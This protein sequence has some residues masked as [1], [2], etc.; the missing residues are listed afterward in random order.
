MLSKKIFLK[1]SFSLQTPFQKIRF[2]KI[3]CRIGPK[4]G[5]MFLVVII[6]NFGFE[7]LFNLKRLGL[8]L[9]EDQKVVW[10]AWLVLHILQVFVVKYLVRWRSKSFLAWLVWPILQPG[11][12]GHG[13][14]DRISV[15]IFERVLKAHFRPPRTIESSD[16]TS[17]CRCIETLLSTKTPKKGKR[18][19]KHSMLIFLLPTII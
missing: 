9:L 14:S 15:Q 1:G 18:H 2:L 19:I 12:N 17:K 6:L 4:K 16:L 13:R 7:Q 8:L 10:L 11:F 3:W 5:V